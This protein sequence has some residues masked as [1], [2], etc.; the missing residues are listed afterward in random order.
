M[1][2][3]R[4]A[5]FW[6]RL[7]AFLIDILFLGV[8]GF[9][10]GLFFKDYFIPLGDYGAIVGFVISIIYFTLCNSSILG[11]QTIGKRLTNL[12]V[13]D[14]D[15]NLLSIKGS[16]I[17]SL[18]LTF[19]YFFINIGIPGLSDNSIIQILWAVLLLTLFI[20]LIYYYIFNK[21][22]RQSL[23][24]IVAKSYVVEDYEESEQ[25]ERALIKPIINYIYYAISILLVIS[26][27]CFSLINNNP[28]LEE[29]GQLH[30]KLNSIDGVIKSSVN[31][32]TT[33]VFG[34]NSSSTNLIC[35]LV[36]SQ[37]MNNNSLDSIE[38]NDFLK[39]VVSV[40]LNNYSGKDKIDNITINFV[41]GY[42]IGIYKSTNSIWFS[43]TPKEWIELTK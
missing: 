20:G 1:S 29:L 36:V 10:L 28:T 21:S 25:I 39:S 5:K 31:L 19:P 2:K 32:N 22:T 38:K 42:N 13:I 4:I 41:S 17:R 15:D 33:T 9:F 18:I 8:L 30:T 16:F 27:I 6:T 43:K 37:K 26:T 34:S 35:N 3:Y 11:G 24:D 7:G 14:C 12:K 40:V 23:H